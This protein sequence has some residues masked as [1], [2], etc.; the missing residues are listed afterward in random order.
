MRILHIKSL[1]QDP[2]AG[3]SGAPYDNNI[4]LWNAV[5][6]EPDGTPWDVGMQSLCHRCRNEVVLKLFGRPML[7]TFWVTFNFLNPNGMFPLL[8][9]EKRNPYDLIWEDAELLGGKVN[10]KRQVRTYLCSPGK[11]MINKTILAEGVMKH[12]LGTHVTASFAAVFVPAV[13]SNPVDVIN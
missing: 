6:F 3:I 9:S 2:L 11:S 5:I 8:D 10:M 1:S 13:A 4:M 12:G 7:R